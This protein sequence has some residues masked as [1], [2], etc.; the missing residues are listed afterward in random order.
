MS[1]SDQSETFSLPAPVKPTREARL[2]VQE[3]KDYISQVPEP[4][5]DK[6]RAES[7][8]RVR[9]YTGE[10]LL[11]EEPRRYRLIA[12]MRQEGLGVRQTCRAA[13]CDART[14]DSVE[15]HANQSVTTI[16]PKLARTFGEVAR[17]SAE[18]MLEELP[19]VPLGQLPVFAGVATDKFLNLIGDANFR[20]EHTIKASEG[21]IFE[22][23][24]QFSQNLEKIVQARVVE[25]LQIQG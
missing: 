11:R 12:S 16:K 2:L 13:H 24:A 1:V 23:M 21:N 8:V 6:P 25:P 19:S 10:R 5:K 14:V 17:L 15:R 9:N 3:S 22:R 7:K 20:I 18:R 4:E